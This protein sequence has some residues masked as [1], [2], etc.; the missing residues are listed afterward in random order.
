MKPAYMELDQY[1]TKSTVARE[2]LR[3]LRTLLPSSRSQLFIEP[4]AGNGDF[5]NL[6]PVDRRTG[7]DLAPM[8]AGLKRGDFL[9]WSPKEVEPTRTTIIGNPPF[10]HRSRLAVSFFNHAAE[11]ADTIAFIVPKQFRKYS[12]HSRL[13]TGFRLI[14]DFNLDEDSF[15]TPDGRDYGVR[16]V[17]QVWTRK[18]TCHED[19]RI[20]TPPPI[21]HHDFEMFLYNN[22]VQ[23]MKFF[24]VDW[25]FAVPRQG[26]EDYT[27]R[28]TDARHCEKNKQWMFFK[29]KN[30]EIR[31]RLW[32]FDFTELAKRNTVVYGYGKADVVDVYRK[33]YAR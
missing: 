16:C 21:A 14:G 20:K 10:G 30:N 23:A 17:F 15:Y 33:T 13:D 11:M 26:Y 22:T 9:S 29:P 31:R 27:R 24:K 2:C 8:S 5:F 32:N 1:Y 19:S 7:I 3:N 4:S 12:V 6:L 28:E 25:D 18:Q